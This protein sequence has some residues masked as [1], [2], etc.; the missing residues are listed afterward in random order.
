M[1]EGAVRRLELRLQED[2][3]VG[4]RFQRGGA[5]VGETKADEE[6]EKQSGKSLF[7][8]CLEQKSG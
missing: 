2:A 4:Y 6:L 3:A 8:M 1:I 5:L 7:V